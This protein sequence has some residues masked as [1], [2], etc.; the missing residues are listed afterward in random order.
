MLD[1]LKALKAELPR[2]VLDWQSEE[3]RIYDGRTIFSYINGGAEVYK[4]YNMRGCLSRRYA[5]PQGPAIVLDVFDMGSSEDAFGVFTHDLDGE[6]LDVGQD[7]L[8]RPGWLRFW[9]DRFFVSIFMEE[10][11][12]AAEKAIKELAESVSSHIASRGTKPDIL[13]LLP[14][15]G[16]REK[17]VRFLHEHM[18]LNYHFYL[19]DQNILKL[20]SETDAVLAEYERGNSGGLVLLI[21]YPGKDA[22]DEALTSFMTHYLPEANAQRPVR[23]ENGRWCAAVRKGALLVIVLEAGARN[24][25]EDLVT[26]IPRGS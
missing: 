10:E 14:A 12:A 24:L 3:D 21:R 4:A 23:L 22:A 7:G 6:T 5:N 26:E 1:P 8:Y 13:K 11:S 17:T 9:K 20:D 18:V 16:L 2:R 15:E 25:A 19:A